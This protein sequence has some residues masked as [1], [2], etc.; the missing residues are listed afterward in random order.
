MSKN[1]LQ[2]EQIKRKYFN[3]LREAEGYSK[4]TLTAI[5]KAIWKYEEFSKNA[6]Y[7]EFSAKKAQLF[8]KWLGTVHNST[9]QKVLSLS[10]QY[11]VLRHIKA[12]FTWLSGQAGYKSRVKINDVSYLRLSKEDSR[13]ATSPTLPK[14]PTIEYIKKL[15][16]FEVHDEIG[17]RD[18]AL[19]AFTALSA[20]RDK[21]IITLPIGC[22]NPETLVVNQDPKFGVRTKFSKHIQSTLFSFDEQLTEFVLDWERFLRKA[23][24]FKNSDPLFPRTKVALK[25]KVQHAFVA[26]GVEPIYW[27]KASAMRKIFK[28]RS[29]EMKLDYFSPHKFRHF[30]ISQAQKYVHSAEELKAVSQNVGHANVNTTFTSYG[31]MGD[32][33]AAEIISGMSFDGTHNDKES[34]KEQLLRIAQSL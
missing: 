17:Q 2:N 7:K 23:K 34:T 19:I 5:E 22:F 16:S 28:K 20:M 24:F 13:K 12:F 21:A 14:H 18:R 29:Q 6:D 4:P 27:Q 25:S 26:K 15:C 3:W 9:T 32:A 10:S 8:K 1:K 30:A 11:H 33:R 31:G